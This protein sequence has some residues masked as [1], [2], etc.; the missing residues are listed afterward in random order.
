[1]RVFLRVYGI[2]HI[3][4]FTFLFLG[5]FLQWSFL[6]DEGGA[7]NWMIWNDT[8][9]ADGHV[10]VAPMLLLV[11][12]VWGVF[13]VRAADNPRAYSSFLDFTMWANAVHGVLMVFQVAADF[14]RYWFKLLTDVPFDLFL[15]LGIYLW[16][17]AGSPSGAIMVRQAAGTSR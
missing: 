9:A 6:T 12:V 2:V 14:D 8:R 3:V 15:S 1:M 11:S 17:R 13:L 4:L 7:L 16:K 10:H 5:V